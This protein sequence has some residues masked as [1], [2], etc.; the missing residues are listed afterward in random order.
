MARNCCEP[1]PTEGLTSGG[2]WYVEGATF[3]WIALIG[4]ESNC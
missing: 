3:P 4:A 2:G 1:P